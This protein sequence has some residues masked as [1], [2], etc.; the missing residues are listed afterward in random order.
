M[1][2]RIGYPDRAAEE[3]RPDRPPRRRAGRSPGAGAVG[4]RIDS[5]A[6]ADARKVRMD[7][8]LADYLL[9]LID[10]TRVTRIYTSA[11]A[12]APPGTAPRG[13]GAGPDRGPRLRYPRRCEAAGP[14]GA[15][16]PAAAARGAVGRRQRS[17]RRGARR[18]SDADAGSDLRSD[19]GHAFRQID[20]RWAVHVGRSHDPRSDLWTFRIPVIALPWVF[21][22][23]FLLLIGWFRS[24]NLLVLLGYLLAA[25]PLLNAAGR[26]TTVARPEGTAAY[27]STR[28]RRHSCSWWMFGS[29]R[30]TDA[31]GSAY[32]STTWARATG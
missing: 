11:A 28:V 12:L 2:L 30:R 6:R 20:R 26:G 9:D 18:H 22:A 32:E 17:L 19:H 10:A 27:C 23:A 5:V 3:A 15:G 1:R 24:I 16:P 25:V 7:E 4:C 21:A 14:A 13:P 8:S 31:L 29:L